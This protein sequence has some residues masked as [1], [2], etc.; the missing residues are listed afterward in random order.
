MAD[1]TQFQYEKKFTHPPGAVFAIFKRE[2][3][4]TFPNGDVNTPL[5][6][7]A[8]REAPGAGGYTFRLDMEIT[9]Y[10]ENQVYELTTHASNSQIYITRYELFPSEDGNTRLVLT[11]KNTTPGFFGS[12]NALVTLIFFKQKAR[13]KAERLF[14]A[15]ENELAK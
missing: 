8:E 7:T 2:F 11:E 1:T 9:D 13:K 14:Q 5:G 6:S 12:G 15:I 10:L 4:K 3:Q